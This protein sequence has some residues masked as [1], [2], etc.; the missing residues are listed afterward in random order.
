M[1]PRSRSGPLK[2]RVLDP[3]MIVL[4]R[5]K[6]A[7]IC[8]PATGEGSS[9]GSRARP[10]GRGY[11]GG[12]VGWGVE[13]DAELGVWVP[14]DVLVGALV[15]VVGGALDG[16]ASVT[17]SAVGASAGVAVGLWSRPG[18]L[19]GPAGV[20]GEGGRVVSGLGDGVRPY[21]LA[22]IERGR[23][24]GSRRR[25]SDVDRV[26]IVPWSCLGHV[27]AVPR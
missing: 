18:L 23:L 13:R 4:S 5:S 25:C 27:S 3:A 9:P 22:S 14:P 20:A 26:L 17:P 12:V 2:A 19:S 21:T 16:V 10:A 15:R 24:P 8:S 6:K 1:S 11:L 7:A